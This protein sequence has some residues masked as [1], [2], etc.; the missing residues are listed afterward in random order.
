MEQEKMSFWKALLISIGI[1]ILAVLYI[2]I[3]S[4]LGLKDPWVAFLCLM[5]W[6]AM[7]MQMEQAP[8]IF[9]G[10]AAGLL[11][12]MLLGVLTDTL[13]P[14]GGLIFVALIVFVIT[15]QIKGWLPL[16]C[17]FGLFLF[18]TIG[19]AHIISEQRAFLQYLKN[20]AFGAILFW[21]IPWVILKFRSKGK[22]QEV[23]PKQ[24]SA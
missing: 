13:G 14:P 11:V 12:A 22:E 18:L 23:D 1:I 19:T 6:G 4:W 16:I 8:G 3:A 20:L 7:G 21:I 10:S 15:C 17:N 2:T 24:S 9:I 5:L